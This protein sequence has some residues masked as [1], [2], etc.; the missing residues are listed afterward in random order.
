[1]SEAKY[2]NQI[3]GLIERDSLS[4][5]LKVHGNSNVPKGTPDIIASVFGRTFAI[6]CKVRDNKPSDKQL[7]ELDQWA[8]GGAIAIWVSEKDL[9]PEEVRSLVFWLWQVDQ[10][11]NLYSLKQWMELVN[12]YIKTYVRGY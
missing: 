1:M 5:C 6:E 10:N 7:Y 4:K 8:E 9:M 3:I 2:V 11:D 12:S